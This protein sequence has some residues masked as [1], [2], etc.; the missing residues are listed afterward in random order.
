MSTSTGALGG[1][2]GLV[3]VRSILGNI[4]VVVLADQIAIPSAGD[5]FAEAGSLNDAA[6]QE[7]VLDLGRKHVAFLKRLSMRM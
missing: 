7:K 5:A 3:T 6:R 4:G 2:C 1:V